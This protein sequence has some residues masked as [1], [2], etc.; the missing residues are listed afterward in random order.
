MISHPM[1]RHTAGL[2]RQHRGVV[3]LE[4]GN[5]DPRQRC[6]ESEPSAL[7]RFRIKIVD[8]TL[9]VDKVARM[10]HLTLDLY[11]I[12]VVGL[13][14]MS[15][16]GILLQNS[17][18]FRSI[19]HPR[20]VAIISAK[21]CCGVVIAAIAKVIHLQCVAPREDAAPPC[22][23][24]PEILGVR[25][26]GQPEAVHITQTITI[27]AL[28]H[29]TGVILDSHP[30]LHLL[31]P[32]KCQTLRRQNLTGITAK[33]HPIVRRLRLNLPVFLKLSGV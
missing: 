10:P 17:R 11:V 4:I 3:G 28:V 31:F 16:V 13:Q 29:H 22:N 32:P 23:P 21:T 24:R 7:Q 1:Q 6:T 2:I 12:P 25:V 27:P 30:C 19:L 26:R 14:Q 33:R 5:T 8:D 20:L 15:L 18:A 9:A